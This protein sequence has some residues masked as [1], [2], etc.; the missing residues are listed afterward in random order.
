M[1]TG[2]IVQNPN[3][4][5]RSF[6]YGWELFT[7]PDEP[8]D[9]HAF[10][11]DA[12]K[13]FINPDLIFY[14]QEDITNDYLIKP[15]D[16]PTNFEM[17]VTVLWQARL[18][19]FDTKPNYFG[20]FGPESFLKG[21]RWKGIAINCAAIF[22]KSITDQGVCCSFNRESADKIFTES[23]YSRLISKLQQEEVSNAIE[24][25]TLP[26]WYSNNDEP[27]TRSGLNMGLTVMLDGY[28]NYMGTFSMN[29]DF[30]GY[31]MFIGQPED[32]PLIK[33]KSVPLIPGHNNLVALSGKI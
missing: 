31:S 28:T 24:N 5:V 15:H 14:A 27:K 32:F 22:R 16:R 29:S 8:M 20:S 7:D 2:L 9:N 23:T 12:L 11:P 19:C 21:C 1:L 17:I 6:E 25:T 13:G 4:Y 3:T 18:S 30:E 26:D 10:G 33:Q